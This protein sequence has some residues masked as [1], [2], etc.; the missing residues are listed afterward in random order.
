MSEHD[1]ESSP[2]EG[3]ADESE[4]FG[5]DGLQEPDEDVFEGSEPAGDVI[6][7]QDAQPDTFEKS[8][9]GTDDESRETGSQPASD[10]E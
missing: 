4:Y 10:R 3:Q 7:L 9:N 8:E 2:S 5:L 1:S 6:D